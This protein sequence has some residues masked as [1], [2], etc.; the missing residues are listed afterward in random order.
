MRTCYFDQ[1][2]YIRLL[3]LIQ[4]PYIPSVVKID[5][6]IF[7]IVYFGWTDLIGLEYTTIFHRKVYVV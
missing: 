7:L 5:R 2:F 3:L 1:Q 6:L 4:L